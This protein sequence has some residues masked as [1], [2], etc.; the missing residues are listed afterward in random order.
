MAQGFAQTVSN[1]AGWYL[2]NYTFKD[3]SLNKETSLMGTSSKMKDVISYKGGKGTLEITYNRY[4]VPDGKKLAGVTYKVG[5]TDPPLVLIPG[6]KII[7]DFELKTISSLSWKAPQQSFNINQGWGMYFVTP[8]G[9]KFLTKDIKETLTTEKVIEKGTAGA[10][11]MIQ[12][13]FG[14][15]FIATYNYEWKEL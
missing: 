4:S 8:D 1:Q 2:S 10:K 13:V 12:M 6:E 15:G 7:V 11:R 9:T 3:G 14:N 5:W